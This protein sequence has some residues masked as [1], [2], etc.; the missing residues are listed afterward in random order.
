MVNQVE[1]EIDLQKTLVS[2]TLDSGKNIILIGH[3]EELMGQII[4]LEDSKITHIISGHKHTAA[5]ELTGLTNVEG[6]PI[7]R[8]VVGAS[9]GGVFGLERAKD[10]VSYSIVINEGGEVKVNSLTISEH[11]KDY[12]HIT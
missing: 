7:Q 12:P 3:E 10:P 11:D 9:I 2:E 1:N 5:N 8:V 4:P 6:K